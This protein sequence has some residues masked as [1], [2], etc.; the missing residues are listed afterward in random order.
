MDRYAV[1]GNPVGHSLSPEIHRAFAAQTGERLRYDKLLAPLDGFADL[2]GEFFGRGGRGLNVT[3]PFKGEACRWVNRAQPPATRCG[4]VNTIGLEGGETLGFNTDGLGLLRDLEAQQVRISGRRL[5]LIGA[6]GAVSGILDALVE[7]NPAS[8]RIANRTLVKAEALAERHGANVE[9]TSLEGLDGR[10][11]LIINGTSAGLA[12]EGG[13]IAPPLAAGAQCY[14]LL[15]SR[16]GQTP[17][18]RWAERAGAAWVSDGLGMLVE[19]AAAA[20]AIWRGRTPS[21][22]N[23]LRALRSGTAA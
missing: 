5:L 12:G 18:C 7:A 3:Q 20:F 10:F 17:F 23:L 21:T 9:A 14:D 6:G 8:V 16:D 19:Q 1:V 15:Y 11:D 2:A 4:A 22:R 13:L